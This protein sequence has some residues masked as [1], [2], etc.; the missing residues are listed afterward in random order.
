M[1]AAAN[2]VCDDVQLDDA[3]RSGSGLLAHNVEHFAYEFLRRDKSCIK[4]KKK[5]TALA[6]AVFK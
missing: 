4:D 2:L 5:K 3:S 1:R 6:A